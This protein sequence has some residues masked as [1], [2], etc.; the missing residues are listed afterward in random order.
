[1]NKKIPVTFEHE[2][3]RQ[4][5]QKL[6]RMHEDDIEI[7]WLANALLL[8][9]LGKDANIELGVKRKKG[10]DEKKT[11]Q[12]MENQIAI[13]WIAAR[14]NPIHDESPPNKSV[15]ISEAAIAFGLDEENLKRACPNEAKLKDLVKFYW[16]SQRPMIN[17]PRD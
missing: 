2:M 14:M 1:M 8:I 5:S 12:Y 13:R 16:D 3:L 6:R 17:K 11:V 15:A 10:Q 9:G 4:L 7:V